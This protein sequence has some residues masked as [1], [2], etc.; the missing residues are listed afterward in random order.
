MAA[1]G[2]GIGGGGSAGRVGD[3]D[4]NLGARW[5][6]RAIPQLLSSACIFICSGGCFG[7][8]EK[9][10]KHVGE[11]S[12]SLLTQD[13]HPTVGE[14]FWSTTTIEVDQA[15]LRGIPPFHPTSFPLDQHGAGSSHNPSEFGF[16]LWEQ[17]REEWT[18]NRK[19]QPVVKQIHEPVLSW[20]AAYESLLGSN[21]PFPQPIPLHEMVDF[22][23]DMWEQEGLYD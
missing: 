7:C 16:S 6:W 1:R 23:V 15:D 22:L 4:V 18:D 11:L 19:E 2:G 8:C 17:I 13:L 9:A 12:K 21:K 10:V 20:N 14:E 3:W 5:D